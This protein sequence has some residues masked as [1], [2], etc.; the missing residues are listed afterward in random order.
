MLWGQL[1]DRV[2]VGFPP[3]EAGVLTNA[4]KQYL[5]DAQEDFALH[6]E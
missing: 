3:E 4:A 1:L 5:I 6:T 2:L